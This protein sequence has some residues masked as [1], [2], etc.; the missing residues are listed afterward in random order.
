MAQFDFL[1]TWQD[2]WEII[3]SILKPGDAS[4]IA[5]V[6]YDMPQ[7]PLLTSIDDIQ[8]Q[9]FVGQRKFFVHST[10]FSRNPLHWSQ[11]DAGPNQG[12][13]FIAERKGGPLLTLALPPCY[14][15]DSQHNATN[16]FE[17]G[18]DLHLGCGTLLCHRRYWNEQ[19]LNWELPSEAVKSGYKEILQRM[20]THL[21]RHQFHV[22]IWVGKDALKQIQTGK[23]SID[24]FGL[25]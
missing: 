1:G 7:A 19:A 6:T 14:R 10:K 20:K 15:Y 17:D 18:S 12:K 16:A 21:V 8:Q 22:P 2:S 25:N 13:N 9:C 5:D 3:T 23:A 24:G 4:L 11:I